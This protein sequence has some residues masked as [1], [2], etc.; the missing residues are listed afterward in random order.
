[1]MDFKGLIGALFGR[2][3]Q[4]GIYNLQS[5]TQMVMALPKSQVLAAQTEIVK[6]LR[7][8]NANPN[9]AVKERFKTIEYLDEKARRLQRHLLE[10]YHGRVVDMDAPPKQ[11]LLTI[12]AFWN[13][14]ANAYRHTLKLY[15]Q[16]PV[17]GIDE[18]QL[19]RFTLRGLMYFSEQAKWCYLRYLKID[20]GIWRNLNRFYLYAEKQNFSEKR[21]S[22]YADTPETSIAAEY[23]VALTLAMSTP[24]K[25][26]PGQ[27]ELV[28]NWLR[29]WSGALEISAKIRPHYH[30]FGINTTTSTPPR[31][32]R[33]D[34]LGDAWRYG[35]IEKMVDQARAALAALSHDTQPQTLGLPPESGTPVNIDLLRRLIHMWSRDNPAPVRRHERRANSKPVGVIRGM[36]AVI[37]HLRKAPEASDPAM[38]EWVLEN[39]SDSGIGVHFQASSHDQL[40]IGEIIGLT[41]DDNPKA[42]TI[43][44]IRRITR[45]ANGTIEAGI[46]TLT[47]TPLVVEL[48]PISA[49]EGIPVLYSPDSSAEN[50]DRFL[51]VPEAA[52]AEAGECKLAA[53]GRAYKIR[54]TAAREHTP[55]AAVAS[56]AV[57]G[58]LA[59]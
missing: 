25:L 56:F 6:A 29:H 36:D 55:K 45:Q 1:M 48:A 28:T 2:R 34:M 8:L 7:Q 22:A 54:L 39:E 10:V 4:N 47:N 50:K 41:Q 9:I 33:R 49:K 44:V 15:H 42:L 43:G 12:V 58:K 30:L 46:E 20:Q 35:A 17:R 14:M 5:A 19:E 37:K 27:I 32:L 51:L 21:L 38:D 53:Q 16:N 24:E 23:A 18:A 3:E 52:Y 13:E 26:L 11:V 40:R 59:D 31:R 57:L